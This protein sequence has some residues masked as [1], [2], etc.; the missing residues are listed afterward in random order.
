MSHFI[1]YIKNAAR[2]LTKP[3]VPPDLIFFVTSRCNAKCGFCHFKSSIEDKQRKKDELRLDE[4]KTIASNYGAISKLSLCG[5]E[6]FIRKDI[7]SIIQAFVYS[8]DVRIIDIPS[9]GYFTESIIKQTNEILEK[10]QNLIL[11]IQLSIDGREKVHDRLRGVKGIY[12]KSMETLEQLLKLRELFPQLRI[13][14]NLTYQEGNESE[15]AE[16]TREFERKYRFD[17]FQITFPHGDERLRKKIENLSYDN[18]HKLSREIQ[19]N[20]AMG[21]SGDFHSLIFRAIKVIRDDV[22]RL[23]MQKGNM[24]THC[25]AGERILVIDDIGNV[26]PCEPLWKSV[27]NLRD[28]KYEIDK[29]LDSSEMTDFRKKYLSNNKCNCTWGCVALDQII[30][31]PIYYP[32]ILY[33]IMYLKFFG[34]RSFRK[35]K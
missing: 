18:F 1:T 35:T 4:I 16:V 27:G 25:G 11:E 31:N 8:C 22:L 15:V 10:N 23:M 9:N 24:G 20:M 30:F 26:F 13:K 3:E 33:Y 12:K 32:K 34:G 14:M 5:G 29:I 28:V 19:L 2:L 21:R 7:P 17:R 6:P